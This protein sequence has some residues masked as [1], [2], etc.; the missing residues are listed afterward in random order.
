MGLLPS[1][2]E[3]RLTSLPSF[4]AKIPLTC[5]HCVI[6]QEGTNMA[7]GAWRVSGN[8]QNTLFSK[9]QS[10]TIRRDDFAA[11]VEKNPVN[12]IHTVSK[13]SGKIKQNTQCFNSSLF[14]FK[15]QF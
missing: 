15:K 7:T 4:G 3:I 5:T 8:D 9:L 11:T 2:A 14:V 1:F 12:L 10:H 6:K 13:T